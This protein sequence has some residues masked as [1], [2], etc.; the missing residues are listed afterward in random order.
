M[1]TSHRM[2]HLVRRISV[3]YGGSVASKASQTA[4]P[5]TSTAAFLAVSVSKQS[6][7]V[8][9]LQ[10]LDLQGSRTE[11]CWFPS[12]VVSG[13]PLVVQVCTETG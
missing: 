8:A 2:T 5:P 7:Y 13:E 4:F 6:D 10:A 9:D 3:Q 12:R 1:P 11:F